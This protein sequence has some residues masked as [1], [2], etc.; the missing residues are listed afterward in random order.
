MTQSQNHWTSDEELLER[1]ALGRVVGEE[2]AVLQKHLQECEECQLAVQRERRLIAGVKRFGRDELKQRLRDRILESS[3]ASVSGHVVADASRQIGGK[4]AGGSQLSWQT[5]VSIAAVILILTG[6][7][8][9][10]NW[11]F[12]RPSLEGSLHQRAEETELKPKA[13]EIEKPSKQKKGKAD[14]SSQQDLHGVGEKS[15][16]A[17]LKDV[18]AG[19]EEEASV[20]KRAKRNVRPVEPS[21]TLQGPAGAGA[22][23]MEKRS[24]ADEKSGTVEWTEGTLITAALDYERGDAKGAAPSVQQPSLSKNQQ[25]D[26]AQPAPRSG[27]GA[28]AQRYVQIVRLD[29]VTRTFELSQK[30]WSALPQERQTARSKRQIP[31]AVK[32][33][34][35]VT[36][37]TLYVDP[38][39]DDSALAN[40]TVLPLGMDSI[41]IRIGN[42]EIGYKLRGGWAGKR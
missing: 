32:V 21:G 31:T 6:I 28:K 5:M 8:I 30:P 18:G 1:Y 23:G 26:R 13:A 2:L 33:G 22:P 4:K 35:S 19:R 14:V 38:L 25:K 42:Q 24:P 17:Q 7:G 39:F 16:D 36:H 29:S 10:N 20:K 12:T 40:A 37:L 3:P 41:V 11:F 9:Y 27:S 15:D 34:S